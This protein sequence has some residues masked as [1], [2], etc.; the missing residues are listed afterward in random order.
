MEPRNLKIKNSTKINSNIASTMYSS[1]IF[2]P[3][4]CIEEPST[5]RNILISESVLPTTLNQNSQGS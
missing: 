3:S 2:H 4:L 1:R 5:S